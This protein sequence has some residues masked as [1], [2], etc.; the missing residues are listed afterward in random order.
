MR[1]LILSALFSGALLLGM[2]FGIIY[3]SITFFPSV[4]EE[5]YNPTL[6]WPGDDRALLFFIHPFILSFALAWFW[7]RFK[8]QFNGV[9]LLRGLEL[10][11]VYGVVATLPSMWITFSAIAVSFS[12]VLTWFLYGILQATV[13]G[14]VF[15]HTNP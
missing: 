8:D 15:A 1:K 12:M 5:Y 3:F 6:F 9:P 7:N 13:A 11:I 14:I 10:G 2:A 4:V